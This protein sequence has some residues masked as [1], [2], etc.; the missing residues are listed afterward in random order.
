MPQ[1]ISIVIPCYNG[2]RFLPETL[3]SVLGQTRKPDEI[4]VVNDGSTDPA[5]LELLRSLPPEIR[6]VHKLNE[7]LGYARNTGIEASSGDLILMLDDDDLITPEC[8]AKMERTLDEHPEASWVGCQIESFGAF[9]NIAT[10]P[11][12]NPFLLL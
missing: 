7:G 11:S 9:Q 6:V 8:L 4:I 1:R 12:F 2:G 10:P 5:T 3:Q